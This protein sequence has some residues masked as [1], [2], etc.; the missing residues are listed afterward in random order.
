MANDKP[1]SLRMVFGYTQARAA[2]APFVAPPTTNQMN[3]HLKEKAAEKE[4]RELSDS[5]PDIGLSLKIIIKTFAAKHSVQDILYAA[6]CVVADQSSTGFVVTG[7]DGKVYVSNTVH[8]IF[9]D[10]LVIEHEGRPFTLYRHYIA[11]IAVKPA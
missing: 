7:A 8:S 10:S 2:G 5:F 4:L 1:T 3:W 9:M 6:K 11:D